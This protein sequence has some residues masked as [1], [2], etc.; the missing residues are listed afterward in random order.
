MKGKSVGERQEN[1][2]LEHPANVAICCVHVKPL[3]DLWVDGQHTKGN[4]CNRIC[5][6]LECG[7]PVGDQM[8][9][10]CN[11][12]ISEPTAL[13]KRQ[14]VAATDTDLGTFEGE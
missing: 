3:Q 7:G 10:G 2:Y 8:T 1:L 6:L 4:R 13:C 9:Y 11:L 12:V 5:L 14:K